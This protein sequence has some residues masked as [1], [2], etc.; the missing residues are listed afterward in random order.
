[1]ARGFGGETS[2]QEARGNENISES[3][4]SSGRGDAISRS[5]GFGGN[6]GS[7]DEDVDQ[8]FQQDLAAMANLG[9]VNR[10]YAM[11]NPNY[12]FG[13][14]YNPITDS[15]SKTMGMN[16]FMN[17]ANT[18]AANLAGARSTLG[19]LQGVLG[20]GNPISKDL[21]NG[22]MGITNTNPYGHQNAFSRILGIDP[23]NIDYVTG[24]GGIGY[25]NAAKIAQKKYNRYSD[26]ANQSAQAQKQAF[27]SLFGNPVGE[28]TAAGPVA[29]QVDLE[30]IPLGDAI[31]VQAATL[32]LG[33]LGYGFMEMADPFST[34]VPAGS[35]AYNE[36][37]D[38][39][40]NKDLP[41]SVMG[42]ASSRTGLGLSSLGKSIG[43]YFAPD[44]PAQT[45]VGIESLT[46]ASYET[47][48]DIRNRVTSTN[49]LTGETSGSPVP[50]SSISRN[51][52]QQNITEEFVRDPAILD[53]LMSGANLPAQTPISAGEQ[54]TGS[55]FDSMFRDP[56]ISP[57]AREI[58][59]EK[60]MTIDDLFAPKTPTPEP[61][62]PNIMDLIQGATQTS[63]LGGPSTANQYAQVDYSNLS[64]V[65]G[66]LYQ[67]VRETSTLDTILEA[68]GMKA[69]RSGPSGQIYSPPPSG[70]ASTFRDY[71]GLS[72]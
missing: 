34:Y 53:A 5:M 11:G 57:E 4:V 72:K 3:Q 17:I 56:M 47:R 29:Q 18:P 49:P 12:N 64:N 40:I 21:Y 52:T 68:L 44:L 1:M 25:S 35:K 67:P 71:L 70:I 39:A 28:L 59:K 37:F 22:I 8:S 45:K 54:L 61:E 33:P 32:G 63:A 9:A 10:G 14:N 15:Y 43:E 20:S 7:N 41:T 16:Q 48:A 66:N 58:L 46:P 62:K 69:G 42:Q 26:F 31:A 6:D 13:Q 50:R 55:F 27:G 24:P 38:P 36:Q 23:K 65:G 2:E 30:N 60:G 51:P 19:R